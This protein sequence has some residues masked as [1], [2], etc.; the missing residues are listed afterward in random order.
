MPQAKEEVG[1]FIRQVRLSRGLTQAQLALYTGIG[2]AEI[3]RI[4]NGERKTPSPEYLRKIGEV[5]H[6]PPRQL[7]VL[8][9]YIQEDEPETLTPW[10]RLENALIQLDVFT[11]DEVD[12]ILEY[13]RFREHRK[14]VLEERKKKIQKQAQEF[15]EK[16]RREFI[17]QQTKQEG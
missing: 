10:E 8:A 2:Q 13:I 1:K 3:S 11:M 9:G 15:E 16:K 17:S 4:E 14:K 12:D 7:M 5:L 6:I